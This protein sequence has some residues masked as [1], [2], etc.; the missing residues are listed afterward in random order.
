MMQSFLSFLRQASQAVQGRIFSPWRK[1]VST[2]A[3]DSLAPAATCL[4]NVALL[5]LLRGLPMTTNIFGFINI[6][7]GDWIGF[8]YP[9]TMGMAMSINNLC[10]CTPHT[11]CAEDK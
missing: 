1:T 3:P 7:L 9:R 10:K 6:L 2:F 11:D 5:P 4:A 8:V